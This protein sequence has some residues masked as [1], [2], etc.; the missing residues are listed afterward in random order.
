MR[1]SLK[2]LIVLVLVLLVAL[3]ALAAASLTSVVQTTADEWGPAAG[4]GGIAWNR[5]TK[6]DS[7]IF[8]DNGGAPFRVNPTSTWAWTGSI[9]GDILTY[10]RANRRGS[11]IVAFDIV[12]R[13]PVASPAHVNSK[14]WEYGPSA[15]GQ[16][17]FFARTNVGYGRK[18]EWRKLILANKVTG[19]TRRLAKGG[20]GAKF[21]P[22]QVSGDWVVWYSCPKYVCD[23]HRYQI[24]SSTTLKIPKVGPDQHSPAISSDGTMY[25]VRQGNACGSNAVIIR[26]LPD[27]SEAVLYSFPGGV[28]AGELY[29]YDGPQQDLY[30]QDVDCGN[31]YES[32]IYKVSSANTAAPVVTRSQADT[33]GGP[34]LQRQPMDARPQGAGATR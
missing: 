6:S 22:G 31:G 20:K 5:Y 28:Q 19:E 23:V 15:S 18:H 16:W 2:A 11:D 27:N 4:S 3:P 12:T 14:W 10:Q 1:N 7:W 8:A 24:S 25:Y 29:V 9:E 26:R 30:L 21:Y 13:T 32:D 17:V 33:G 34:A